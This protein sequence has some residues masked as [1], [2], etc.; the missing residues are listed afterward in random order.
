[1]LY[2]KH[3]GA[4]CCAM[5][6]H[7]AVVRTHLGASFTVKKMPWLHHLLKRGASANYG[8][9]QNVI[10]VPGSLYAESGPGPIIIMFR[11]M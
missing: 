8:K 9:Y 4:H 10:L 5:D 11:V 6:T 7:F 1:M 2:N 3:V